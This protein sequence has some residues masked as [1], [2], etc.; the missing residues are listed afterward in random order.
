MRIRS[1][2]EITGRYKSSDERG[3]CAPR[4][5]GEP[6]LRF[7]G[8]WVD[9]EFRGALSNS[10]TR[11]LARRLRG[12]RTLHRRFAAAERRALTPACAPQRMQ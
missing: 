8:A 10:D 1:Y 6:W 4:M 12:A 9:S 11:S 5:R 3:I 7:A 2:L